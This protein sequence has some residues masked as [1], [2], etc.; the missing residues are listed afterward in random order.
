MS[1]PPAI[2]LELLTEAEVVRRI[3]GRDADVRAWLRGLRGVRRRGPCG[4]LYDWSR[5]VMAMPLDD[6]EPAPAPATKT[7]TGARRA[8]LGGR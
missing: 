2:A 3:R 8:T 5:V 1:A 6:E 4:V 7:V